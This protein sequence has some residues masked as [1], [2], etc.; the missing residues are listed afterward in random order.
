MED[1]APENGLGKIETPAAI[2]IKLDL[3]TTQDAA[4]VVAGRVARQ[5]RMPLAREHHVQRARQPDPHRSRGLPCAQRGDGG[6]PVR[7]HLL[8]AESAA[9]AQ[10]FDRDAMLA[11]PER[12]ATMACV[13]VGCCVEQCTRTPPL[14][15]MAASAHCVS[16]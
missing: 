3:E 1:G 2:G 4:L 12:P 16:R 11:N 15:S 7:L 5:E 13:S 14:S 8:A 9:H 6:P 10:T